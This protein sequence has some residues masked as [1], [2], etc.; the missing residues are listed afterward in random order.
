MKKLT[1]EEINKNAVKE[2]EFLFH[3]YALSRL[4]C[5]IRCSA[6][7]GD[8]YWSFEYDGKE[9]TISG[10]A[11]NDDARLKV[12]CSDGRTLDLNGHYYWNWE[13]DDSGYHDE[14]H[15][16]NEFRCYLPD[17]SDI[18]FCD[19]NQSIIGAT[20]PTRLTF[21]HYIPNKRGEELNGFLLT[22]KAAITPEGIKKDYVVVSNSGKRIV[23]EELPGN[24][25]NESD[26]IASVKLGDIKRVN[27]IDEK[28]AARIQAE[29]IEKAIKS[30][31][32]E[33]AKRIK[34]RTRVVAETL[35][36]FGKLVAKRD[37]MIKDIQESMF[38]PEEI[39]MFDNCI[40]GRNIRYGIC[41]R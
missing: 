30:V 20:D 4:F 15:V 7:T 22:D 12:Q 19:S 3:P 24:W 21:N 28:K 14:L 17:E 10:K 8:L 40:C 5:T 29:L 31:E 2:L 25:I 1:Q 36:E 16:E 27:S 33:I 41:A 37:K 39:I 11:D 35:D 38:T 26:S 32:V 34:N 9:Y 6:G 23:S 18:R 13:A